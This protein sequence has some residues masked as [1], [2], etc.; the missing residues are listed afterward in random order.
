MDFEDRKAAQVGGLGAHTVYVSKWKWLSTGNDWWEMRNRKDMG[1][2]EM[3]A[4]N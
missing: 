4:V 3:Q 2:A 1:R